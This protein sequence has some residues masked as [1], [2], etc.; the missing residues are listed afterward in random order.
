M[1]PVDKNGKLFVD[2]ESYGD[3]SPESLAILKRFGVATKIKENTGLSAIRIEDNEVILVSILIDDSESIK[4]HNNAQAIIKGHNDAIKALNKSRQKNNILFRTQYLNGYVLND[5]VLLKNA[6]EMDE[7]NYKP[8]GTTPLYDASVVLLGSV[9]AEVQKAKQKGKQARSAS[10]IVTDGKDEASQEE[11][12]ANDVRVIVRDMT[13]DNT[14]ETV[15]HTVAFMGIADGETDYEAVAHSMGIG[16]DD[17]QWI[18]KPDRVSRE[19]RRAFY[20]FSKRTSNTFYHSLPQL[21]YDTRLGGGFLDD[22]N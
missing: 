6:K 5:W 1:S 7:S 15:E 22:D 2:A 4:F 17:D 11:C 8:S 9:I 3:I 21:D 19:I 12:T 18:L 16:V 13:Q 20:T 14:P 10:L